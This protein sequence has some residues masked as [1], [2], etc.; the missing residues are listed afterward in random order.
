[1]KKNIMW[2]AGAILAAALLAGAFFL[3]KHLSKTYQP[4]TLMENPTDETGAQ[5]YQAPDFT[6]MDQ[7]GNTVRLSDNF[8]TPIVLNFWASWCPPCKAEMPHFEAAYKTHTDIQFLMVNATSGDIMS[9][10]KKLIEAEGYTFPVLF[11]TEGVAAYT[12]GASSLPITFFIDKDG[13]LVT[14]A[15]GSLSAENLER[16]IALLQE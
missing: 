14:Y 12:Y 8:G 5:T 16:G 6:A 4:D 9:D 3:Y 13:N 10:A 7:S 11:D 15:I 1:M 2:L